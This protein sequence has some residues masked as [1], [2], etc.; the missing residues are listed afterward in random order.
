MDFQTLHN[1]KI[2]HKNDPIARYLLSCL[3][4]DC[5]FKYLHTKTDL[6]TE[7]NVVSM[8]EKYISNA[9]ENIK[10]GQ[11]YGRDISVYTQELEFLKSI[12]P[13]KMSE[14]KLK[15]IINN[16]ITSNSLSNE[17]RSIGIVI[18]YLVLNYPGLFDKSTAVK[19]LQ[20]IF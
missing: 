6:I 17:K 5:S 2:K 15:E 18:N 1:L 8:I 3:I 11:E 7:A 19:I 16:Y 13:S 9:Q 4:S 10:I 20:E 12:L 14:E